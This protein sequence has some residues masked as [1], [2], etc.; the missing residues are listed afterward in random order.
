MAPGERETVTLRVRAPADA[1]TVIARPS[2]TSRAHDP[3]IADNARRFT[4]TLT[5]P[6]R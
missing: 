5:P 4:T 1:G 2:V 3:D 6:G